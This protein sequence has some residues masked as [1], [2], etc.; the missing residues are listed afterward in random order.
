M[1]RAA[2]AKACSTAASVHG[3]PSSSHSSTQAGTRRRPPHRGRRRHQYLQPSGE[4]VAQ[5]VEGG[6]EALQEQRPPSGVVAQQARTAPAAGQSQHCDLVTTSG[7]VLRNQ[8]FQH[9][10]RAVG[11]TGLGHECLAGVRAGAPHRDRP[12]GLEPGDQSRKVLQP[13]AGSAGRRSVGYHIGNAQVHFPRFAQAPPGSSC[14]TTATPT[15]LYYWHDQPA[16]YRCRLGRAQISA[17]RTDRRER[18]VGVR[19]PRLGTY[20]TLGDRRSAVR[21]RIPA[22]GCRLRRWDRLVP[23]RRPAYVLSPRSGAPRSAVPARIRSLRSGRCA[24]DAR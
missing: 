13:P 19:E 22:D 18:R 21:S 9:C 17:R 10:W 8:T 15:G 4:W 3:W 11:E 7:A 20:L 23:R 14:V 12:V 5:L 2:Q 16:P 6:P 1:R 24:A